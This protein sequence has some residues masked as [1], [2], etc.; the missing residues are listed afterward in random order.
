MD[1]LSIADREGENDIVLM[2]RNFL[3]KYVIFL[4]LPENDDEIKT[5]V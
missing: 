5:I 4:G 1:L 2:C 3:A